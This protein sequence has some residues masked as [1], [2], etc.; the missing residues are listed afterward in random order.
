METKIVNKT[1]LTDTEVRL[2]MNRVQKEF[3]AENLYV[4]Y[5]ESFLISNAETNK[6][7]RIAIKY[8]KTFIKWTFMEVKR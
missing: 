4:G 1:D 2:L 3:P 8:F 7:Y 6:V 5:K